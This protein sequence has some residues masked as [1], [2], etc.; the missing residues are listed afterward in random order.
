[1]CANRYRSDDDYCYEGDDGD[2]DGDYCYENDD[3]ETDL[4]AMRLMMMMM[5]MMMMM[6]TNRHSTVHTVL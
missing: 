6:F 3:D 4:I 1:L 2:D 5:M